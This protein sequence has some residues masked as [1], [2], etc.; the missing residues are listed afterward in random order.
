[1]EIVHFT[2]CDI[3]CCGDGELVTPSLGTL[4]PYMGSTVIQTHHSPPHRHH[5][6][7]PHPH[8]GAIKVDDLGRHQDSVGG[9]LAVLT[10][11]EHNLMMAPLISSPSTP[12]QLF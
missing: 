11:R 9:V 4:C 12:P 5:H 1:M 10:A 3:S 6:H 8:L 7:Q 2:P